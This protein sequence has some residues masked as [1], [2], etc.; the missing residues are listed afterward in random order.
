MFSP[1]ENKDHIF[2]VFALLIFLIQI[3]FKLYPGNDLSNPLGFYGWFDQSQYLSELTDLVNLDFNKIKSWV[4]PPG[5]SFIV[6]PISFIAT[7]KASIIFFSLCSLLVWVWI[8]REQLPLNRYAIYVAF[9]TILIFRY[10]Q[11]RNAFLVPWSTSVTVLFSSLIFLYCSRK[12]HETFDLISAVVLI[13]LLLPILFSRIQDYLL[14][15]FA[16][17][18]FLLTTNRREQLLKPLSYFIV[19]ASILGFSW[20]LV[21]KCYISNIYSNSVHS[22]LIS[23]V[24]FKII[25]IFNGD[26]IYGV[27]G[28]SF[29]EYNHF[30]YFCFLYFVLYFA[31]NAKIYYV[32]VVGLYLLIYCS[33]SDFGPHNFVVFSLFH[34]MKAL[35]LAVSFYFFYNVDFKKRIVVPAMCLLIFS[36][37]QISY[38]YEDQDKGCILKYE[39]NLLKGSC[40]IAKSRFLSIDNLDTKFPDG[41][42]ES[43][44]VK[45]DGYSF[46]NI[47]DFRVFRTET[48]V[49]IM[50]FKEVSIK[51][52]V[53]YFPKGIINGDIVLRHLNR[54]LSIN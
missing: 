38:S 42:F 6:Y 19:F 37:L 1:T 22:F 8:I 15:C 26:A 53:M 23:D 20:Y 48:G 31:F 12:K 50:F 16:L 43:Y 40:D 14:C 11:I 30:L 25:G 27:D 33:F 44:L 39:E 41:L 46:T 54:K 52:F 2:F 47:K 13:L 17:V 36:L 34:Y 3:T 7:P 18:G 10:D 5:F 49:A 9:L 4:Y 51:D 24:F 28:L 35:F 32:F 45:N 21:N 29:Y